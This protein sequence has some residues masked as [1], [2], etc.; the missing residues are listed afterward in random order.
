MKVYHFKNCETWK[1]SAYLVLRI[2][3]FFCCFFLSVSNVSIDKYTILHTE[4]SE[5]E[6][7][8]D[9]FNIINALIFSLGSLCFLVAFLQRCQ[10]SWA[11]NKK[12]HRSTL[13]S[14]LVRES[15]PVCVKWL[16]SSVTLLLTLTSF[17]ARVSK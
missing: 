12:S 9:S 16:Y 6:I 11:N 15:S 17:F 13:D 1:K 4:L 8:M 5:C 10:V 2:V 7:N 3:L 14:W